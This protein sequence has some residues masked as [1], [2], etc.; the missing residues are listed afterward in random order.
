MMIMN[1][2]LRLKSTCQSLSL[3]SRWSNCDPHQGKCMTCRLMCHSCAAP[4]DVDAAVAT[5]K[6]KRT[7][8]F[9]ERSVV[10]PKPSLG[11]S[12]KEV[13]PV[14]RYTRK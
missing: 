5:I 8:Q 11:D 7:T 3:T 4:K 10:E 12:K 6:R 13:V 1:S 14:I 9:V 2:C